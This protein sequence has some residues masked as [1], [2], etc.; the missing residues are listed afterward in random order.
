MSLYVSAELRRQVVQRA[1]NA[2]EYCRIHHD[3][4][5]FG[6]E[7][8]H[9]IATKHGGKSALENLAFAC[10]T[11]NRAKGS[12]ISSIAASS[13]QIVRL[14]NPRVD[15]WKDHFQVDG[16][17]VRPLTEIGEATESLLGF[18]TPSRR[19]ERQIL[20]LAGRY[21]PA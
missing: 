4:T 10:A 3:D 1:G 12:D 2:C 20:I 5:Y 8:D 16:D 11:C 7:V 17:R 13:R 18:N 19:L 6:C 14:F 15:R 21:R 9:V